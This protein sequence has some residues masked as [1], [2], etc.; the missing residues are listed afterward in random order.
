MAKPLPADTWNNLFYPPADYVYFEDSDR[1]DFEPAAADFS[2]KNAW[3]MADSALLAYVKKWDTVK[4]CLSRARLDNAQQIG[5]DAAKSTKGFF[6]SRSGT[7]PFAIMAFRG[8]DRD[9]PRNAHTDEDTLP[10]AGDTYILHRGFALAFDQVWESEVQPMLRAFLAKHPGAPVYFTGH[11]LG[12]ALATIAAVRFAGGTCALYTFGSPR[13]GDDR[14]VRAVLDKTKLVFRFVNSQDIVTQ[15]PP[16]F[17]LEHF[18]RH[19]GQ[20]R[21]IDRRGVIHEKFHEY[22]KIIDVAQGIAAH[23]GSVLEMIG[24]PMKYLHT[25]RFGELPDPPPYI[26]G[27]HTPARYAVRIWNHYSQS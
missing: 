14:F 18:F 2:W 27:N 20:E 5:S 16:E 17:P 10:F 25:Q 15:I 22:D 4:A 6:A 7:T 24:D 3:W 13:V 12:A 1:F 9:D 19:V 23:A 8:T 26:V 11:S 21:Y